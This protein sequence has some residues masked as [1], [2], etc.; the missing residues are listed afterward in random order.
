[1]IQRLEDADFLLDQLPV[2]LLHVLQINDFDRTIF[3]APLSPAAS[4]DLGICSISQLLLQCIY[5]ME[6]YLGRFIVDVLLPFFL[7][8]I[9]QLV[10]L[11]FSSLATERGKELEPGCKRLGLFYGQNI[12][13]GKGVVRMRGDGDS[14]RGG[15]LIACGIYL[16]SLG[17]R[18]LGQGTHLSDAHANDVLGLPLGRD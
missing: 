14:T 10:A 16:D 5:V 6:P 18:R 9:L 15:G 11:A 4:I 8:F 3:L 13:R 2:F 1:M 7:D 12:K 17:K